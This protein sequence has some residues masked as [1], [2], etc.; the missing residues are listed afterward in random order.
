MALAEDGSVKKVALQ[1]RKLLVGD[2]EVALLVVVQARNM[3]SKSDNSLADLP[4]DNSGRDSTTD[5]HEVLGEVSVG[6]FGDF[7]SELLLGCEL[8]PASRQQ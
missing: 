7:F 5:D 1:G 8:V 3:S 4:D 6:G 2:S